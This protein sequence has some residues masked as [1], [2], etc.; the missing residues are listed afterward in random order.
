MS[1]LGTRPSR[2][3]VIREPDPKQV[4]TLTS[5]LGLPNII[6]G[7]L[8]NRDVVDPMEARAYLNP[9]LGDLVDP[10]GLRG[11]AKAVERILSAIEQNERIT[12]YGD[13]DV[14][15]MTSSSI[16][17]RFFRACGWPTHV[18]LPDRFKDGYGINADRIRELIDAGTTLFITVDCGITATEAI[19]E[20]KELGADFII[21]DHHQPR[22]DG[23]PPA[24]AI[25]NPHQPSCTFPFKD[26][27]AAGLAFHL[28]MGLRGEL[29]KRGTYQGLDEP[30][31]R[32]LLDIVAIGTIADVVPLKGLN[33]ILVTAG[34][35][36]MARSEHAGVRALVAVSAGSRRL[37]A[38][39][40]GFQMGPRLNAAGRLSHPYKGYE[41]LSTDDTRLAQEIAAD[42]DNENQKRR[43]VQSE[44]EEQAIEQALSLSEDVAPAYV[45][46]SNDWHPGVAGI[47]A[48]RIVQRFHRPCAVIAVKDGIGKGSIRS[49]RGFNAVAGLRQCADSLEQFGGHPHAAGVTVQEDQLPHFRRAFAQAAEALT[50][51]DDLIP[52]LTLDSELSFQDL[53][54]ELL[55]QIENLAPFGAGNREPLFCTRG[56]DV[57]ETR[58]VGKDRSHL[59]M[60]LQHSGQRLDAIAFGCGEHAPP[61]GDRID[62]AYR[63]EYNEWKG[64]VSLQL[65]VLD[66]RSPV[67][68]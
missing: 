48:A 62:V 35:K 14:D 26:L 44:I 45:L 58:R 16:L 3:W 10:A 64:R 43:T 39:V 18:F 53:A 20:A 29:R 59:R 9:R 47:V 4:T 25:I 5:E 50:K 27:C 13:Y 21:V 8:V 12:I 2:H 15:G 23:L 41:L 60:K 38:G 63:P 51:P 30:D 37:N 68:D 11:M 42:V 17:A 28:V 7:L 46:W 57:L 32:K 67:T 24:A 52:R 19:A 61:V 55:D 49:I 40:V 31:I 54:G 66:F 1:A 36:R 34:L 33:R 22:E 56:V 65:R 6:A